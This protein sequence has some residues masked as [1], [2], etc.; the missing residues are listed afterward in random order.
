VKSRYTADCNAAR[1]AIPSLFVGD[2]HSQTYGIPERAIPPLRDT[3]AFFNP[4]RA[5]LY[6]GAA[7]LI[8]PMPAQ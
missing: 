7:V 2:I 1:R 4:H 8:F 6:Q 5:A 3:A